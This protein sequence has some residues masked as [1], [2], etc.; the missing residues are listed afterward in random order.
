MPTSEFYRTEADR[1]RAEASKAKGEDVSRWLRLA[2]EYDQL[3]DSMDAT[4]RDDPKPP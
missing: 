4:R 3:A 1:L 2:S